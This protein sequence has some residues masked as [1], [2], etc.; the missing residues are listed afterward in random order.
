MIFW[1]KIMANR[2]AGGWAE[3]PDLYI[4]PAGLCESEGDVLRCHQI[5]MQINS[6]TDT[7]SY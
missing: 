2:L 4:L 5:V 3:M 6:P 1:R 7:L